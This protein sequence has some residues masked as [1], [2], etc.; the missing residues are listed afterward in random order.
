MKKAKGSL[1][2][3]RGDYVCVYVKVTGK[4]STQNSIRGW[5]AYFQMTH[6][7]EEGVKCRLNNHTSADPPNGRYPMA[8]VQRM[9]SNSFFPEDGE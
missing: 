9:K 2:S 7:Y 4:G 3:Q 8:T 1:K 6:I 5:R